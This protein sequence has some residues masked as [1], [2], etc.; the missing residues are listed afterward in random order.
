VLEARERSALESGRER[1]ELTISLLSLYEMRLSLQRRQADMSRMR[2]ATETLAA[3]NQQDRFAAAAMTMCNELASR[4]RC[5]RASLG[6]LRGRY[7][8]LVAMSHAEKFS[9]KMQIAQD[10][11]AAMEECLDQDVEVMHPADAS[12]THAARASSQLATRHGPSA[13]VSLPIRRR[14]EPVGAVTVERPLDQPF[15]GDE[16]ETLRLACDLCTARLHELFEHDRWPGA[17]AGPACHGAIGVA[18]KATGRAV[19][20]I[21]SATGA[22][23]VP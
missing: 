7:V 14:G 23:A 11:E 5:Q 9:R 20:A 19:V 16:V 2:M 10:I 3:V 8:H 15:A 1:L 13:V 4:W 21:D 6:F 17:A 22:T 12:A 18:A